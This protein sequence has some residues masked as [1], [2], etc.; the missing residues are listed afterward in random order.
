MEVTVRSCLRL[1]LES[2]YVEFFAALCSTQDG[3]DSEESWQI[4]GV[5]CFVYVNTSFLSQLNQLE[6]CKL[7]KKKASRA[8]EIVSTPEKSYL[9][10]VW[11]NISMQFW[12]WLKNNK[13]DWIQQPKGRQPNTQY[14]LFARP[15]DKKISTCHSNSPHKLHSFPNFAEL[16]SLVRRNIYCFISFFSVKAVGK[17]KT[18][19]SITIYKI[20]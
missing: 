19:K 10:I 3:G 6:K 20:K 5:W 12:E 14:Y 13:S 17:Q 1:V 8:N 7:E 15:N 9:W 18:I 4:E 2:V 11:F 16:M